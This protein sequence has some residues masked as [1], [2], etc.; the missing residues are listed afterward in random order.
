MIEPDGG[1]RAERDRALESAL[2]GPGRG[3]H[4]ARMFDR[5]AGRYDR[6]NRLMSLGQDQR[7]RRRMAHLAAL[8]SRGV[9]LDL[10]TGT[11]D[12]A[13]ALLER[14]PDA[15]V[16]GADFALQ[17][18]RQGRR[19]R[20]PPHLYFAG[21]DALA[22][23]FPNQS[24]DAVV[25]AYLMRNIADIDRGFLEQVRVLK[26]GGRLVGLEINIPALPAARLLYRLFFE[27]LVPRLG[28]LVARENEAYLYLPTSVLAYPDPGEIRH[29][30]MAAGLQE[31]RYERHML[32]AITIHCGR[33]AP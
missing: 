19:K 25:H 32:G 6:M 4:V 5:I 20:P 26:P 7:W 1:S 13:L 3:A 28:A 21:A 31:V 11:G 15:T 10:A 9:A 12:V 8:P 29:R 18:M 2:A 22:L 16:V 17:M 24:F 23:P 33:R 27:A 14:T 30:M